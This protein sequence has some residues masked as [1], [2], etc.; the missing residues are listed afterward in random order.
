M[1][2]GTATREDRRVRIDT[3]D[4][5]IVGSLRISPLLRTQARA[6]GLRTLR[7]EAQRL[8]GAGRTTQREAHRMVEGSA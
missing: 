6:G 1:L 5:A 7:E 4:G 3:V 2:E 8:V